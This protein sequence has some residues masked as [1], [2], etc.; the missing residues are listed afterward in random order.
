MQS[1]TPNQ[2]PDPP[3]ID[4]F[5]R[6]L[7]DRTTGSPT[8]TLIGLAAVTGGALDSVPPET[9]ELIRE[10]LSSGNGGSWTGKAVLLIGVYLFLKRDVRSK[11]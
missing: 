9:F 11:P 7:T 1:V 3:T 10:F 8:S 6:Q 2:A 4:G 5:L